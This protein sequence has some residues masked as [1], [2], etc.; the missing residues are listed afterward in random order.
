MKLT[1]KLSRQLVNWPLQKGT[2]ALI[3]DRHKKEQKVEILKAL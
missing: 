2:L 3:T 1:F